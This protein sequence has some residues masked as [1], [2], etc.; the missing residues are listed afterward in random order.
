MKPRAE[1]I[2]NSLGMKLLR[3]EAGVFDGFAEWG[4]GTP[5]PGDAT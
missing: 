1:V 4:A 2:E 3:I 5:G